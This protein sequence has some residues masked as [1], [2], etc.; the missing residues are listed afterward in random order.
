MD[1]LANWDAAP[2]QKIFQADYFVYG[3]GQ[4]I[5]AKGSVGQF[6]SPNLQEKLAPVYHTDGRYTTVGGDRFKDM[7]PTAIGSGNLQVIGAAAKGL[8]KKDLQTKLHGV[9]KHLSADVVAYEQIGGI[10]SAMYGL[11]NTLPPDI[12]MRVDF[13]SADVTALRAHISVKYPN[14]REH[15]ATRII[16]DIL[17]HRKTG[18]HPHG[19]DNWWITHW[20]GVLAS[21]DRHG[22]R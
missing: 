20:T 17:A 22:R 5:N 7:V 10:R 13:S 16:N 8:S 21:W 1:N 14:I 6:L 19:Y 11:N 12:G 4:N 18:H 9:V 15:D 2:V 3:I